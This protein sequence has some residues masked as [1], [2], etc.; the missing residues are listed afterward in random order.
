[1]PDKVS[2]NLDDLQKDK[3][4]REIF[5]LKWGWLRFI[6][7]TVLVPLILAST[8]I[9]IVGKTGLFDARDIKQQNADFKYHQDTTEFSKQK[10]LM[11]DT[12]S[13]IKDSMRTIRNNFEALNQRYINLQSVVRELQGNLNKTNPAIGKLTLENARQVEATKMARDSLKQFI[14][15]AQNKI[16]DFGSRVKLLFSNRSSMDDQDIKKVRDQISDMVGMSGPVF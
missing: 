9:Y 16:A 13:S 3:V 1:M 5:A 10:T 7:G 6:L 11:N 14:Y 4:K 15:R 12:I 8:T 2:E